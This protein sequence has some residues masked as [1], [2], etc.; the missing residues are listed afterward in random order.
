MWLYNFVGFGGD[1]LLFLYSGCECDININNT[2][3]SFF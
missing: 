1:I 2:V 3:V